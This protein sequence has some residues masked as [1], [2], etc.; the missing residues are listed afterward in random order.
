MC[1]FDLKLEDIK[2]YFQCQW[3]NG[4][5]NEITQDF[6]SQCLPDKAD[7]MSR[8]SNMNILEMISAIMKHEEV[9]EQHQPQNV[10]R[11][12]CI[13]CTSTLHITSKCSLYKGKIPSS[14]CRICETG[15]H[16]TQKCRARE[17]D[18]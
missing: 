17:E 3:R 7:T 18:K 9:Y 8:I 6:K 1:D 15:F 4:I 14:K 10:K 11:G 16:F 5:M 2:L 13:R 12:T